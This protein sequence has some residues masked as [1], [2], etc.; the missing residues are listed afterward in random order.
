MNSS[1]PLLIDFDGVINISGHPAPDA[2]YFLRYISQNN[3]PSVIISNST[4]YSGDQIKNFLTSHKI[5]FGIQCITTIDASL[6]YVEENNLNIKVYCSDQTK[7]LFNPFI[8]KGQPD[9]VII[10]DMGDKWT[11][12]VMNDIFRD[13]YNGAEIIAMQKNKFWKPG[14]KLCLDAGAY[15]AAIEYASGKKSVLIGKPSPDYFKSSLKTIGHDVNLPFIM[16]GDDLENDVAAAQKLNGKGVLVYT[17]KTLYP[18]PGT[19]TI[20]PDFEAFN[21]KEIISYL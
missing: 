13:V 18:L 1:I 10:G 3:I 2:E 20:K 12:N 5:D 9:A 8:T 15:I 6:K 7:E 16:I 4:L 17:G 19:N 14:G 21:L 11:Y